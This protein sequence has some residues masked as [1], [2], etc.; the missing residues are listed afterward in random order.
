MR[1]RLLKL[2]FLLTAL[3]NA[4]ASTQSTATP[5]PAPTLNN[6][7]LKVQIPYSVLVLFFVMGLLVFSPMLFP[8]LRGSCS[9]RQRPRRP[10][11]AYGRVPLLL[12]S[13]N[14]QTRE[15]TL[16]VT[17]QVAPAAQ[18]EQE[19]LEAPEA[20]AVLIVEGRPVMNGP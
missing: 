17:A 6:Q 10:W 15:G 13:D 8:I 5:T 7:P 14:N 20:N 11:Q 3:V 2:Q 4:S 19:D 12:P 18:L 1:S 16:T 9:N